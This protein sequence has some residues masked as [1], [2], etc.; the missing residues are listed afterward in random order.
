MNNGFVINI[1]VNESTILFKNT[2]EIIKNNK[3]IS[4]YGTHGTPTTNDL[5][6]AINMLE[7]SNE[8]II[9][10]SRL[11]GNNINISKYT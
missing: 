10:C 6:V 1:L 2:S 5:C 9:T 4:I 7:W 3:K 8:T 11:I